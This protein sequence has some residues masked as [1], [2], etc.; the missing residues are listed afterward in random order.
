MDMTDALKKQAEALKI[1]KELETINVE[2]EVKWLVI[3]LNGKLQVE[4]VY[5]ENDKLVSKLSQKEQ[6]ELSAAIKDAMN[7]GVL[8]TQT[9]AAQLM[10]P[11]FW[12][13]GASLPDEV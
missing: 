5:F 8:H 7:K 6:N 11:L 1:G 10:K 13:L 4:N 3:T 12:S 2:S 9:Q